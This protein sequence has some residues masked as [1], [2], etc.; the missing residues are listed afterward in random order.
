MQAVQLVGC[1]VI[2]AALVL[3]AW[4]VCCWLAVRVGG[5]ILL[6][7]RGA[8]GVINLAGPS[9]IRTDPTGDPVQQA[10]SRASGG[11]MGQR[12]EDGQKKKARADGA[13]CA[14]A[15]AFGL[16]WR[17]WFRRGASRCRWWG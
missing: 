8:G 10:G 15:L 6:R 7:R 17:Q 11:K 9:L 4:S 5:V 14:A 1:G 16:H 12:R 3:L 13:A 2:G